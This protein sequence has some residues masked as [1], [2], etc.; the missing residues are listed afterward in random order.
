MGHISARELYEGNLEAGG[1]SFSGD[2][3]GY[4]NL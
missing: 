2:P 3:E 4:V 1:G